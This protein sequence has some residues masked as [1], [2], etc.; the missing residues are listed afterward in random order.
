MTRLQKIKE[1]YKKGENIIAWLKES[2]G[3]TMNSFEDIMISYDFQSG[4]YVQEFEKNKNTIYS[5][6]IDS[7]L[8]H[9]V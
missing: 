5:I 9:D 2:D 3:R 7:S 6:S 4:T 1:H 8:Q